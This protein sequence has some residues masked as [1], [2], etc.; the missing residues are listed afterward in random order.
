MTNVGNEKGQI[1]NSVL[2]ASE[3]KAGLQEM[4]VGIMLRYEA[5]KV[6]PPPLCY[7]DCNC[8]NRVEG[9]STADLFDPDKIRQL[10]E[11]SHLHL[12]PKWKDILIRQDS[13][14][15]IRRIALG[16][17][18][19]AHPL[20]PLLMS[21]L[22]SCIFKWDMEDVAQLRQ[23]KREELEYLGRENLTLS[24]IDAAITPKE[25][26]LFCRRRTRAPT[27]IVTLITQL[28]SGLAGKTNTLG[29]E[30]LD[31]QKI[32]HIWENQK[33]HVRCLQDPPQSSG[34]QLY[35]VV[36]QVTRKN[37]KTALN[38]LRCARGTSSLESFHLHVVRWIPG[39]YGLN[40]VINTYTCT[41][42]YNI[43]CK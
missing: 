41:W 24:D 40:Y 42:F 17:T 18:T 30:L 11:Y 9:S 14:H 43:F 2:T 21:R 37:T 39:M 29:L 8:C 5:A 27:E 38:L 7:V 1:L 23:S 4:I 28:L 16:C 3:G 12:N 33:K 32:W 22:T 25:M 19:D 36:K 15:F 26:Q 6:N 35:T 10:A 31:E 13:L 20:F 34:I